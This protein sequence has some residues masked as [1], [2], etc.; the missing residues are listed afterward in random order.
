MAA[1]PAPRAFSDV[2]KGEQFSAFILDA[3]NQPV[4]ASAG[5]GGAFSLLVVFGRCRFRLDESFV[6]RTLGAI[7]GATPEALHVCQLED[8]IFLFSVSCKQVGLAVYKIKQF[9]CV[10]FELFFQLFN[11]SG[12]SFA[13]SRSSNDPV[14]PWL[15]AGKKKSLAV[16]GIKRSVLT[17][18]N[19]IPVGSHSLGNVERSANPNHKSVFER[20]HFPRVSVFERLNWNR[21]NSAKGNQSSRRAPREIFRPVHRPV[22]NLSSRRS[23]LDLNLVDKVR[24]HDW[25][26]ER[27]NLDLNLAPVNVVSR[28]SIEVTSSAPVRCRRCLSSSHPRHACRSPIKCSKCF[29]WGHIA[30]ACNENWKRL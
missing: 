17:G 4:A 30:A 27:L 5:E 11:D 20:L 3:F 12:L 29:M 2:A 23:N 14:F 19:K 15:E 7:L 21:N 9:S 18:A 16:A 22:G 24:Q 28:D 8:R 13:R 26:S 6:A 1:P 25:N 10:E